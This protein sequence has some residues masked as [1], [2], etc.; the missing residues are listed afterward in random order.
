MLIQ[1]V[2]DERASGDPSYSLTTLCN[3]LRMKHAVLA[4]C[5]QYAS[6]IDRVVRRSPMTILQI[7][8]KKNLLKDESGKKKNLLFV[9]LCC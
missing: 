7:V 1:Y 6:A 2:D 5:V 4:S 9:L 3:A 8:V